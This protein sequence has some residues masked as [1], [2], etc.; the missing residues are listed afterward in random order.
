MT[1]TATDGLLPRGEI[2]LARHAETEWSRVGRH[3]GR[4]DVPLTDQGRADAEDLRPRLAD[5]TF[6][7]IRVSPLQRARETARLAGIDPDA[8]HV[9]D[10]EDLLEWDY[11][12]YEG[13]STP[14]IREDRPGWLLWRDGC[15]G[16]E[17]AADVGVRVDRVIAAVCAVDGDVLIVAHGHLLRVLGARWIGMDAAAG[18]RLILETGG[19]C[20]LGQERGARALER[21][22]A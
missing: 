4:T 13:I 18:A 6:T 11:G 3:T 5:H 14:Q 8:P 17:D 19:I 9:V 2:W 22:N 7:Q 10:D 15:P 1:T 21:W 16:G 20:V 12:D